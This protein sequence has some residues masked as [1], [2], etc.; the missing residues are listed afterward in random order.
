MADPL[1][2]LGNVLLVRQ[3]ICRGSRPHRMYAEAIDLDVQARGLSVF[4]DDILINQTAARPQPCCHPLSFLYIDP[5]MKKILSSALLICLAL[6]PL[7]NAVADNDEQ[8]GT[9]GNSFFSICSDNAKSDY[10]RLFLSGVILGIQD[11]ET[12]LFVDR[13][14]KEEYAAVMNENLSPEAASKMLLSIKRKYYSWCPPD[15]STTQQYF[16]IFMKYLRDNPQQRHKPFTYL[17]MTSL[18]KAFPCQ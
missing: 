10:C 3:G 12:F 4:S 6:A 18:S 9:G 14:T 7:R 2:H 8:F 1:L 17:L 5:Y 15:N 13:I 11:T 16:D